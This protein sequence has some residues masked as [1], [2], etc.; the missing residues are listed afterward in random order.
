MQDASE[1]SNITSTT[2]SSIFASASGAPETPANYPNDTALPLDRNRLGKFDIGSRIARFNIIDSTITHSV[3]TATLLADP[4]NNAIVDGAL[5]NILS[6]DP[7][8]RQQET[9]GGIRHY[10][11][12]S[13]TDVT[14]TVK[15]LSQLK[16]K[17]ISFHN[18]IEKAR[19]EKD[20]FMDWKSRQANGNTTAGDRMKRHVFGKEMHA[21]FLRSLA[22]S[23]VVV[24]LASGMQVATSA[25]IK[26]FL[27]KNPDAIPRG[28]LEAAE[29]NLSEGQ[30]NGFVPAAEDIQNEALSMMSKPGSTYLDENTASTAAIYGAEAGVGGVR[31]VIVPMADS[32]NEM[33]T[34]AAKIKKA[35]Q[36]DILA[37]TD[38]SAAQRANN[39]FKL[40]IGPQM[41]SN[42]QSGALAAGIG[43]VAGG[44]TTGLKAAID[45]TKAMLFGALA[46]TSNAGS[47]AFRKAVYTGSDENISQGLKVG[48]RVAGRAAAQ[49]S[50]QA[51]SYTQ[52]TA[53]GS[54]D[55]R[56]LKVDAIKSIGIQVGVSG[57][58]KEAIG[59][60]VQRITSANLP[61]N[62]MAMLSSADALTDIKNLLFELSGQDNPAVELLNE[63]VTE[64]LKEELMDALTSAFSASRL[65]F[66]ESAFDGAFEAYERERTGVSPFVGTDHMV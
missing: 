4:K 48:G 7:G 32:Q 40:T 6:L 66:D 56:S 10:D 44:E 14:D 46:A 19:D 22:Q 30:P 60:L 39:A 20:N 54:L 16:E 23:I 29:G 15:A 65:N 55:T 1:N 17:V 62:D 63:N 61:P 2:N 36:Q 41:K 42:L 34:R 35:V 25:I 43:L 47:D 5:Q 3:S 59:A 52:S 24:G 58:A 21:V 9:E 64:G 28:I 18:S 26:D 51:L 37:A 31:G 38:S 57:F 45:I 12:E 50:K 11:I 27:S 13:G 33:D 53:E 8:F 49:I